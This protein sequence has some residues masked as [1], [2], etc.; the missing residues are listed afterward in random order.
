[1]ARL[2]NAQRPK[3]T[4]QRGSR[5]LREKRDPRISPNLRYLFRRAEEATHRG[6][7]SNPDGGMSEVSR[8]RLVRREVPWHTLH[9]PNQDQVW[10]E[11]CTPAQSVAQAP[12]QRKGLAGQRHKDLCSTLAKS[13]PAPCERGSHPPGHGVVE[14]A[15]SALDKPS[16]FGLP[17][18]PSEGPVSL[19]KPG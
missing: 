15:S 11:D 18:R 9:R 8:S 6:R 19:A 16:G 1:M 4:R 12:Q 2:R 17:G 10:Q 13:E 5:Y 14:H 7:A 3:V